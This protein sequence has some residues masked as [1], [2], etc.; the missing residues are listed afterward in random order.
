MPSR[1]FPPLDVLSDRVESASEDDTDAVR[2]LIANYMKSGAK[3]NE[4][5]LG[6]KSQAIFLAVLALALEF[7]S[8]ISVVILVFLGA[9]TTPAG[10]VP[11]LLAR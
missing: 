6:V 8:T 3:E 10:E 5:V 1:P 9:Q 2:L 4:A 11:I 7:A